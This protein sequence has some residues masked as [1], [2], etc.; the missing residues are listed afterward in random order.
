M[1][2]KQ[3]VTQIAKKHHVNAPLLFYY[4]SQ[5][6]TLDEAVTAARTITDTCGKQY[7]SVTALATAYGIKT[8]TFEDRLWR[9]WSLEKALTA[10]TDQYSCYDHK[11]KRYDSI[12][13]M[14]KAYNIPDKV[15]STRLHK[16]WSIEQ[17]LLTSLL[18][19]GGAIQSCLDPYGN[20]YSSFAAMARA[21]NIHP[22]TLKFRLKQGLTLKEAL[23]IPSPHAKIIK[24]SVERIQYTDHL[25][26]DY[27][28]LKEMAKAWN[29]KTS[30]LRE[31][32][33]KGMSIQEALTMS[34]RSSIESESDIYLQA[35]AQKY[36][37]KI[38]SIRRR[39]H[40]LQNSI[41]ALEQYLEAH[42]I[43][44]Y[45]GV[46]YSDMQSM[47]DAYHVSYSTYY[48]R[49]AAGQDLESCLA[50]KTY[51]ARKQTD[52]SYI[53]AKNTNKKD[54]SVFDHLGN[55]FNNKTAMCQH[56][57][58][59]S[60][61]FDKYIAAGQTVEQALTL[62]TKQSKVTSYLV[63]GQTF[64]SKKALAEYYDI[65]QCT[66]NKWL[67]QGLSLEDAITTAL[68]YK[69]TYTGLMQQEVYDHLGN[70]YPSTHAMCRHY[71]INLTNTHGQA[72]GVV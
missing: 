66:I 52:K 50:P 41:P 35:L 39:Y 71:N 38:P 10:A 6:Y 26:R 60:K 61:T 46:I 53:A 19:A 42:A 36:F 55:H 59:C 29:I 1:Y 4:L 22:K 2:T 72:R 24:P 63:F 25:G 65:G 51:S 32:L 69:K 7:D 20:T 15:L 37:I 31:R 48:R 9:G 44:D 30:T 16:G 54:Q 11:G 33:N 12:K 43:K 3:E 28:N 27:P 49:R 56:Y 5:D 14:A 40:L 67:R 57:N 17:A 64:P 18:R 47:L 8:R 45:K 13:A 68:H 34:V 62:H 70:K 23:L 21:Y 58:V